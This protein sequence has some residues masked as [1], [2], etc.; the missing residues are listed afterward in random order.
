MSDPKTRE[1]YDARF[2]AGHKITGR[3]LDNIEVHAPCPFCAS[4]DWLVFNLIHIEEK[5]SV[6]TQCKECSRSAKMVYVHLGDTTTLE[7]VQTG[8]D[9]PPPYLPPA[10][11][12]AP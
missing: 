9:S 7:V 10:R 6:S 8:G 2:S 12:V 11:R 4:P 3:G 1:E 5:S